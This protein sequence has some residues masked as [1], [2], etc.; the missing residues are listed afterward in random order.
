MRI[1]QA[2]NIAPIHLAPGD[3]IQLTWRQKVYPTLLARAFGEKATVIEDVLMTE[4]FNEP[5]TIDRV[6][7][8]ELDNGELEAL[9]MSQGIA[10]V[11]GRQS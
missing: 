1:L 8:V 10:G 7:I 3:A 5:R 11:F 4:T 6:A 2:E 9:G